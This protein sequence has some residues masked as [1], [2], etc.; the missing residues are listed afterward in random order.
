M[1][2]PSA[3]PPESTDRQDDGDLLTVGLF[4][5]FVALIVVVAALLVLPA[6]Y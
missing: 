2:E 6:L 3:Q 5:Y 4:V 1:V